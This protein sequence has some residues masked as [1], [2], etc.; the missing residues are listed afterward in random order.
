MRVKSKS[1]ATRW[2]QDRERHLLQHGPPQAEKEVPTLQEFA[3]RFIDGHVRANRHKPSGIGAKES[4]LSNHLVP[5]LGTTQLDAITNE[6]V[7]RLKRALHDRSSK[8]VNNVLSVLSMSLKK[9]IEWEVIERMP[10]TIRLLPVQ[11]PSVGFYDFD[12]Y[13]RLVEA[14]RAI[15]GNAYLLVL[16]GGEAGLRC[17]EMIALE[18]GDVDLVKRLLCVQR[19]VWQGHVTAPKGGRLRYVP[20]TRRLA[21]ALREHRHLRSPGVVSQDDGS[22]LTWNIAR[23]YIQRALRRAQVIGVGTSGIHRLRHTFC[24]HLAMRGAPARAIQEMAGHQDLTTTQRYMHLS[25]AAVESAIR[26]LETP[27]V[28]PGRGNMVA[29]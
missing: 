9:A 1:A 16:L 18:W 4:I 10:C 11:K 14:A 20:L 6:A 26:L 12:E 8:T 3:P 22:P 29:T 5:L 2:G 24:S 21:D 13:E 28:L 25:P 7:Q 15:H 23:D 27:G 19:S 17:G